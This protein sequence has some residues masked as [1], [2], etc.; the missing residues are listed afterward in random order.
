[1]NQIRTRGYGSF[2]LKPWIAAR[3]ILPEQ[4]SKRIEDK[5]FNM[6][7]PGFFKN[8]YGWSISGNEGI[9]IPYRNEF[10][11]ITG[12]QIRVDHVKNDVEIDA[13]NYEGLFAIVKEQP[14]LVQILE[15]GEIVQER[16]FELNEK[17][18]VKSQDGRVGTVKLK[19]GQRYFWLSSANKECGT[20][21]GD[22]IPIHIAVPTQQ[23]QTW[24]EYTSKNNEDTMAYKT[25]TV[26]LTEGALKADIAVEHI[27]KAFREEIKEV[28]STMIAVAGINSWRSVIPTLEN[29]QVKRINLAFD[30][31]AVQNP[32]VKHHFLDMVRELKQRG[33][34]V[35][36]ALWNPVNKGIDDAL[37]NNVKVQLREL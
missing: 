15:D 24:N 36:V 1:M 7:I 10:N 6:G 29:M 37:L 13:T 27:S 30:M 8:E 23:L 11:Y 17:I 20:G 14:N 18:E 28:G 35:F 21:A 31:D 33:Y 5:D 26:W 22:P 3:D 2:P 25:E 34:R 12:F 19:K 4:L 16:R 32:F 9:L